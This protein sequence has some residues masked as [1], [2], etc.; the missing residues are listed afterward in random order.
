[1]DLAFRCARTDGT[2]ADQVGDVLRRNHVE[3]LDACRHAH[4]VQF[5]QKP[6]ANTKAIVDSKTAVEIRIVDQSFPADGRARLLKINTHHD[7]KFGREPVFL[8]FQ[9]C[10]IFKRCLGIM[11]RAWPYDDKQTVV[12]SMQNSIDR[13]ARLNANSRSFVGDRKLPQDMAGRR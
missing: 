6:A 13:L 2:P 1:M 11:D 4:L 3:I 8:R 9:L 7:Q 5:Q 12:G 10:R